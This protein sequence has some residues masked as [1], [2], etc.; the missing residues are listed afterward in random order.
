M[1]IT[2]SE[3]PSEMMAALPAIDALSVPGE[4]CT[5]DVA[6]IRAGNRQLILKRSR[7]K[8]F[9]QWLRRE[10]EVLTALATTDLPVPRPYQ[11]IADNVKGESWLLMDFKPGRQIEDVLLE[12]DKSSREHLL[13]IIGKVLRLLHQSP[14]P[15]QLK[16]QSSTD[17]LN[18]MLS[19]AE[20]NMR[21]YLV[22][23]DAALLARLQR[24]RPT[25]VEARLIHGDFNLENV[26]LADDGTISVIDWSGGAVGDPRY[27]IA[28]AL[29][30]GT[31]V[32]LSQ[33]DCHAFFRGYGT[34]PTSADELQYFYH[35]Y[36]FFDT[37]AR[38]WG[39]GY[40]SRAWW[41][42]RVV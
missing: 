22:D 27:D 12:A 11:F 17:W 1:P 40:P 20:F 41:S 35:I 2:L 38:I 18:Q 4:G 10:F 15:P 31:G 30:G 24:D 9:Q 33:S 23:G 29:N 19:E 37:V 39:F 14:V 13:E 32:D 25:P 7:H 8:V 5:S 6:L 34:E 28:L 16:W 21:N 3:I 42:D 36:E 26:L